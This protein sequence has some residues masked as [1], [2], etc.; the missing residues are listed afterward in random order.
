MT[1]FKLAGCC[2]KPVNDK[3]RNKIGLELKFEVVMETLLILLAFFA[4]G[5]FF[6]HMSPVIWDVMT[7]MRYMVAIPGSDLMWRYPTMLER[8]WYYDGTHSY[9]SIDCMM[10]GYRHTGN[11]DA[12]LI[13]YFA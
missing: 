4:T 7:P 10:Y 1:L 2:Q 11:N 12:Q 9:S 5:E 6:A 3:S 8:R 13:N